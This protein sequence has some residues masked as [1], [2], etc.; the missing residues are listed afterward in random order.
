M[1]ILFQLQVVVPVPIAHVISYGFVG[2]WSGDNKNLEKY[3]KIRHFFSA[4]SVLEVST[5][6]TCCLDSFS[7]YVDI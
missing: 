2:R 4:C 1:A 7:M 6:S 3:T 5:K